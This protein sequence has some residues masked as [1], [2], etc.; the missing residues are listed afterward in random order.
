[1]RVIPWTGYYIV[2]WTEDDGSVGVAHVYKDKRCT[3]GEE[4]CE[5]VEAVANHLRSGGVRAIDADWQPKEEGPGTCPICG[6]KTEP[7][8]REYKDMWRC[9]DGG[10][11]HFWQWYG[12]KHKVKDFMLYGRPSGIPGV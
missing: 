4:S 1:M 10:M 3:C 5:H 11:T 2:R 6:G 12:E 9:E 8:S 7:A